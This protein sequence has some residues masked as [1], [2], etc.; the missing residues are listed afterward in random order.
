MTQENKDLSVPA[1]ATVTDQTTGL[2][3]PASLMEQIASGETSVEVLQQRADRVGVMIKLREKFI[4]DHMKVG[5]DYGTLPNCG[6]KNIMFQP[7]AEKLC[8]WFGYYGDPVEIRAIEDRNPDAPYF[9]YAYRC[10]IYIR[11]TQVKIGSCERE[12]NSRERG[13][14]KADPF[15]IKDNVRAKA[16]KRAFVGATR[17][18]TGTSDIFEEEDTAEKESSSN[19][20]GA[21]G[22]GSAASTKRDYGKPISEAQAK[23]LYAIRRTAEINDAVFAPWL[24]AKYGY[25]SDREIGWKAY[26]EICTACQSGK[27]EMPA[28]KPVEKTAAP[29]QAKADA[30][31]EQ[32]PPATASGPTL[33]AAQIK[34]IWMAI[35]E[36]KSDEET[37]LKFLHEHF[38]QYAPKAGINDIL[39]VECDSI[40]QAFLAKM[41]QGAA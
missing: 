18:A 2:V 40:R 29:D 19:A 4:T 21:T 31:P 41:K 1:N 36:T 15:S 32:A 34:S 37:F 24:K 30:P 26:E 27:L 33:N 39:G 11:G 9:E 17:R 6:E 28:E 3:G 25:D 5:I 13:W 23:R 22:A 12:C 35:G 14:G 10:T 7:C 16:Q 38:K 8:D 20:G